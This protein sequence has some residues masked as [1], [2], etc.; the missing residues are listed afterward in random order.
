MLIKRISHVVRKGLMLSM[1]HVCL[2]QAAEEDARAQQGQ[3]DD[4][5]EEEEEEGGA[6]GEGSGGQEGEE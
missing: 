4:D 6:A 1:G 5:E 2:V 3:G